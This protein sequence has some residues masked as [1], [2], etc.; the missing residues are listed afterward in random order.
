MVAFPARG[1]PPVDAALSPARA[2]TYDYGYVLRELRRIA[3]IGGA[4]LLL[5][6]VL[7]FVL[8]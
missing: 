6:V 4:T 8:R 2:H 3:I 7:S 5:V 1:R